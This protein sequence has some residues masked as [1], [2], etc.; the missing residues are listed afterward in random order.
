VLRRGLDAPATARLAARRSVDRVHGGR[1]SLR[2]RLLPPETA[3]T[4]FLLSSQLFAIIEYLAEARTDDELIDRFP[5]TDVV[6][7]VRTLAQRGL[8][9]AVARQK[10]LSAETS[11]DPSPAHR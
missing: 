10:K 6:G 5:G 7:A 4:V 9:F 1:V 2:H 11:G 3:P 8:V